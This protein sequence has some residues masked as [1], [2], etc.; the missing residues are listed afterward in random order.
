MKSIGAILFF[1][2]LLLCDHEY[3]P[4]AYSQAT[5]APFLVVLGI[6]QDAGLPQAGCKRECCAAAWRDPAL[7][8][9][10]TSLAIVDS[11]SRQWWL[12]EATPSFPE[13]LRFLA[14]IVPTA[15]LAGIFLT[16]GHIGHYTGL[17]HLG[18][19]VMGAKAVPVYVMPRMEKFLRTNGPWDQLVRL[20]NLELRALQHDSAIV[21]NE[22]LRITP[23]LVPHRDE[24]TE[25]VGFR[26]SG[27]R[28]TALFIP[29]IDKWE[30]WDRRIEK[31]VARSSVAYLDGTFYDEGE[32]PGRNMAEIP[33]PF[34]LETMARFSESAPR[35]RNKIR[36]IHLNHTNPVL[37][38]KSTA[39]QTLRAAGF[40]VAL[41]GERFGL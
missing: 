13:Q 22:R 34:I 39:Y 15:K 28:H 35:E 5:L 25:T 36:F 2:A 7:R 23:F 10:A 24:Y 30:K 41:P 37:Q 3:I 14:E 27:P 32:V 6:A 4:R 11:I 26:I 8:R 17:M 16:H 12:I 38:E 18:R 1:L 9:S 33:H 29:D 19:E 20:Q 40:S 21:L 31:E